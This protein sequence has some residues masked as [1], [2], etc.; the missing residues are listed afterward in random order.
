VVA[1]GGLD[2]LLWYGKKSEATKFH[3]LF[4]K[5]QP[6]EIGAT[7]YRYIFDEDGVVKSLSLQ[8]LPLASENEIFTHDNLTS[9]GNPIIEFEF[10]DS[11]YKDRYK[12]TG[13]GLNRLAESGRID[14]E[15]LGATRTIHMCMHSLEN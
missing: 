1:K 6:G 9:Q 13:Q 3:M 14:F 10:C 7:Q 12:T 8:E 11:K 5:K 2:Y 15:H 4:I